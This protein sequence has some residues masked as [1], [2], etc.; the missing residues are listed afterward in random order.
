MFNYFL[1][2]LFQV[3]TNLWGQNHD[4]EIFPE[5]HDFKPDRFL[6][7]DGD[8]VKGGEEPRKH[9]FTFGAGARYT[10][11]TLLAAKIRK[12]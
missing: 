7:S 1:Q 11:F 8:L 4:P 12:I 9:L 5:P 10:P 3:L 6:T 2:N